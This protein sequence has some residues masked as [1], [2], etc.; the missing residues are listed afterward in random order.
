MGIINY[1]RVGT[2]IEDWVAAGKPPHNPDVPLSGYRE[3]SKYPTAFQAPEFPKYGDEI[4]ITA[5][6]QAFFFAQEVKSADGQVT[7][8]APNTDKLRELITNI[9]KRGNQADNRPTVRLQVD[10][11]LFENPEKFIDKY[12][13]LHLE[14]DV[15]KRRELLGKET[16]II[17][18]FVQSGGIK[19][20]VKEA[21]QKNT[22]ENGGPSLPDNVLE[23]LSKRFFEKNF[24]LEGVR[25]AEALPY[26]TWK[27]KSDEGTLLA[28]QEY[29]KNTHRLD[30]P[31]QLGRAE[32][33]FPLASAGHTGAQEVI[34]A[35]AHT[36]S[37][38]TIDLTFGQA[39]AAGIT[40]GKGR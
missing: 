13:D 15:A 8:V 27:V 10:A 7:D 5:A 11:D 33:L 29:T 34:Q 31:V 14:E 12:H 40:G 23:E 21:L 37:L 20:M 24:K 2:D 30:R 38:E 17:R 19:T 4:R 3:H 16:D 32:D 25:T 35:V 28:R 36:R 39:Q 6:N 9:I 1:L 22:T 18:D 26:A